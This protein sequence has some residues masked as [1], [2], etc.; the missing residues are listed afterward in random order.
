MEV[1]FK[2]STNEFS[3]QKLW[4]CS[5]GFISLCSKYYFRL[6]PDFCKSNGATT[7]STTDN[8]GIEGHLT[9]DI[10]GDNDRCS[11]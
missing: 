3:Q 2:D 9:V 10:D 7:I 1:K 8:S 6:F 5:I 11:Y 4:F